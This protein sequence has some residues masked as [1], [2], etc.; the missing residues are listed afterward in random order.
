M[1]PRSWLGVVAVLLAVHPGAA[2]AADLVVVESRGIDLKPGHVIDGA[3]PLTLTEGQLVTLITPAGKIIKLRGPLSGPAAE[4]GAGDT[5]DVTGALKSLVTEHGGRKGEL[6]VVRGGGGEE[7]VPPEPWL[8]DV[9]RGGN[10]CLPEQ[11]P[12]VF[13][14]PGG[15]DATSL[16]IAPYDRSWHARAEWPSGQDRITVPGA[17]PIRQR[18]TY[19]VSVG[20]KESALTLITVPATLTNDEMRAA[21][22]VEQDCQP[23]ALALLRPTR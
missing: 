2:R 4:S 1:R 6:A 23:Q 3:K 21:W 20:G 14:R 8:I 5:V 13:W 22:M 15:G 10:R 11:A 17:V 7:V 16:T 19:V 9:T 18:T 12:V